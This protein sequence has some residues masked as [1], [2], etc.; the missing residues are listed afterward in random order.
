M[1]SKILFYLILITF[2]A[3]LIPA[4]HAQTFS[5]IHAF[6]SVDGANPYAGVTIR[7]NSLYG[8]TTSGTAYQLTHSGANW[9][10][11]DIALFG[12]NSWPRARVVFGPDGHLYGTTSESGPYNCGKVFKLTPQVGPCKDLRCFWT[13]NDL[14]DFGSGTDGAGPTY[15]DITWDQQG[16]IYNTTEGGGVYGYGA[17]YE[18]T[19]SGN[20]YTESVIHSFS[21]DPDGATPEN[22]LVLDN[23]GNLFG[24]T[25]QGGVNDQG[26]IFE[27]SYAKGVGWTEKALYSF[28]NASDGE[29]PNGGLMFDSSSGNLYGTT[30][31]GGSGS[32]GTVFELSPSGDTWTFQLLYSISGPNGCG[33]AAT[34]SMD[35]AGNLYGTTICGGINGMGSV[36]KLSNTQNG[37]VYTS[38]YDFTGGTDG[39]SPFSNVAI[40]TDGTLYGT[41]AFGGDPESNGGVVWMIKP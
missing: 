28:Q 6:S 1:K 8:T 22:G 37:W 4:M 15:G 3:L 7:G 31:D 32:G 12:V 39:Y 30:Y 2:F 25:V 19:P 40:G 11:S 33:P 17:V 9:L 27:L 35:G 24:T 18:L 14:H 10:F 13:V 38:L 16:N 34:V 26:L 41:T 29:W 23:K 5:V 21:E 36:F 20:G